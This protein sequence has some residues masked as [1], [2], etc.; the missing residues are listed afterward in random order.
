MSLANSAFDYNEFSNLFI[1]ESYT[2]HIVQ[3]ILIIRN[4]K[5]LAKVCSRKLFHKLNILH[6]S[7]ML[8]YT[9]DSC[10]EISLL[11]LNLK[12]PLTLHSPQWKTNRKRTL[13]ITSPTFLHYTP[14]DP[15]ET[16]VPQLHPWYLSGNKTQTKP[17]T[18]IFNNFIGNDSAIKTAFPVFSHPH[19]AISIP[20]GSRGKKFRQI[21][22]P[23]IAQQRATLSIY[24]Y[25]RITSTHIFNS[26]VTITRR[27]YIHV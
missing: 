13:K 3:N 19:N 26:N 7:K 25:P 5:P 9:R 11:N 6:D 1:Q 14:S 24:A 18:T 8:V 2:S 4:S 21:P 10:I 23:P 27:N 20:Q 22:Q 15:K 12:V 16:Y 17:T